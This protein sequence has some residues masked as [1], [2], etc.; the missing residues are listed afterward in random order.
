MASIIKV[1]TIQD[2]DGNNIINE[3]ANTITIGASGDAI[4]IPSGATF[5][6]VGIDDNA[7]STAITINSSQNVDIAG[8]LTI[9]NTLSISNGTASG[10]LQ[11]SGSFL[12]FGTSTAGDIPI[13]T[14]NAERMR[15]NS[16]G[17]VGIGTASPQEKLHIETPTGSANETGLKIRNGTA[18]N[19]VM[20]QIKLQG[21]YAATSNEA[22]AII[23]GGRESSGNA[24][25]I[26]FS[27]GT[28]SQSERMRITSTGNVGIGTS[29]PQEKLHIETPTGSASETGLKIRNGTSANDVMAQIKLQGGY[30]ATSTEATAIISGG[31][32]SSSNASKLTFSTGQP[33]SE[34]MRI[35]RY[36]RVGI[37]TSSPLATLHVE[38]EVADNSEE[39]SFLFGRSK[40]HS[41]YVSNVTASTGTIIFQISSTNSNYRSAL[42]KLNLHGRTGSAGGVANHPSAVYYFTL[43]T[44]FGASANF[45][46]PTLT[47]V[48]ENVFDKATDFAFSSTTNNKTCT[49]TFTNPTSYLQ[50]TMYYTLEIIG[51]R[52]NLDS[53]T[54]T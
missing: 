46:T 3:S 36:G 42:C 40:K 54:V 1:D 25:K 30:T 4:T 51:E 43:V 31:R 17:N 52:F 26:T 16:S 22:T 9:D 50:N 6:S 39:A 45:S 27:T 21:G 47:A 13:Y 28:T 19:D 15:I 41:G 38:D 5:A 8:T 12:Q 48:Y 32:E 44:G 11:T 29:S 23:S 33:A 24:S 35:D 49:L 10:F 14:N 34:R 53:V 37:G 2:Q 18:V 7:T 20:A